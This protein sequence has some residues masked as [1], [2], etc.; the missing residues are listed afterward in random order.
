MVG[1]I[2]LSLQLLGDDDGGV[3]NDLGAGALAVVVGGALAGGGAFDACRRS[4]NFDAFRQS[5]AFD[6]DRQSGAFDACRRSCNFDSFRLGGPSL[7]TAE[8][9]LSGWAMRCGAVGPSVRCPVR[10]SKSP[11]TMLPPLRAL[12]SSAIS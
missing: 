9:M 8:A 7:R 2:K 1:L 3:V 12:N 6:A 10:P 5:G 11:Q 4:C